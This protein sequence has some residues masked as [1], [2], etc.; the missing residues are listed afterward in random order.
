M[1]IIVQ[2]E[3]ASQGEWAKTHWAVKMELLNSNIPNMCR[4]FQFP[5]GAPFG[6]NL[7]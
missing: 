7:V 4:K 3:K 1:K 6:S 2:Q 5:E